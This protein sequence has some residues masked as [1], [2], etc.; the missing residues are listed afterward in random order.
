MRLRTPTILGLDLGLP[1]ALYWWRLRRRATQ[2]LLAAA[3]IAVGVALVFGVLVAN[4]SINGSV[5]SLVHQLIGSAQVQLVARSQDGFNEK[6]IRE[7]ERLHGVQTVSPVLR[8]NVTLIGVRKSQPVQLIGVTVRQLSLNPTVT[9]GLGEG[10]E[11]LISGGIALPER[12]AQALATHP[13]DKIRLAVNGTIHVVPVRT[14]LSGQAVGAVASSPVAISLLTTA[15]KL[16]GENGRVTSVL[17]KV[18]PNAQARIMRQLRTIAA[19]QVNIE[20]A[21]SELRFFDAAVKPNQQSTLLFAV[22]AGMVGF[23]LALNAM[24][25]TVPERRRLV[26]ELRTLGYDPAQIVLMLVVQAMILGLAGSIVGIFVGDLFAHTFFGEV[27]S[28]LTAAFPVGGARIVTVSTVAIAITCGV[29]AALLAS[30]RPLLDLR[31]G[32]PIDGVM[33]EQGEAGQKISSRA[34]NAFVLM[35]AALVALATALALA[36]P[37]LTIFGGALLAL[38]ATCLVPFAYT[39]MIRLIRPASERSKGSLSIAVVELEAT[40]TRSIALAAVAAL[41]VYGSIAIGGA[42]ADLIRG[43]EVAITQYEDT[44]TIW[45]TPGSN[46][47]NTDAFQS[48]TVR[49]A[50]MRVPGVAS[51]RSDQGALLD[52]GDRRLLIRVHQANTPGIIQASQVI[53]GNVAQASRLVR[54]GGWATVSQGYAAE[55]GLQVGGRFVLPTPSGGLHLGV[56]AI[57]TN[58]GWPV[59]AIGLSSADYVRGWKTSKPTAFEVMLKP[60]VS[61]AAGRAAVQAALGPDSALHAQTFRERE[62]QTDESARQGLRSLGNIS[63]LILISGALAVA[64][65]L[66]A[67]IWQRRARLAAMKTWGYD[68]VQL[69]RS[70]LLESLVLLIIGCLDGAVLGLYGHALAD[71]WLR[72]TTDFPAPFA[73]GV[74]QMFLTLALLTGIAML[75]LAVPGLSAAQVSPAASFQE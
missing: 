39:H 67:A 50:I 30:A 52:D 19:G 43:L 10:A 45:V 46:V 4:T 8:E 5:K 60:G 7:V 22:I 73:I 49:A 25:M 55:H 70:L 38:A 17:I 11:G 33:H 68:H 72:I 20:P 34:A 59:G 61:L 3:G 56:A 47:F 74:P 41:A 66:S 1:F 40:A 48:A 21:D 35:A 44:A 6:T 16:T 62:A 23:L 27:P 58:L 71:R 26:A 53:D 42:R 14:I 24:L 15:Q 69:W 13:E 54:N 28:Y 51:V 57:T 75:V 32:Q 63:I 31:P 29:L 64:A 18:Q 2:E 36:V 65:S 9:R 37:S 12:V